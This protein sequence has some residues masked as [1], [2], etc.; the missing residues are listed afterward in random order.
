MAIKVIKKESLCSEDEF[1]QLRNEITLQRYLIHPNV[2]S[3]LNAY[4]S[5]TKIYLIFEYVGTS[6]LS[7]YLKSK[8]RLSEREAKQIFSQVL[9]GVSFL[10]G[11]FVCH[12]DIKAENI[13]MS[14]NKDVKIIDFGFSRKFKISEMLQSSCGS[15]F[16]ASPEIVEGKSYSPVSVDL[17]SLGVLL[18]YLVAG[19][20]PFNEDT[21]SVCD[22]IVNCDYTVPDHFSKDLAKLIKSI[23]VKSPEKR[24]TFSSV[25]KS[26][27][28]T[29]EHQDISFVLNK[30]HLLIRDRQGN[31][32]SNASKS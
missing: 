19:F 1:N 22:K 32:H 29:S 30:S 31:S 21:V 2:V 25:L 13:V 18:F 15:L 16:Y 28:V 24:A 11:N 20:Y 3:L 27:W 4:H 8:G 6:N 10:H 26:S 12:R 5:K 23:L 7:S 9:A 14:S 17:W